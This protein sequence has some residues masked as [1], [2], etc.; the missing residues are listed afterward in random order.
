MNDHRSTVTEATDTIADTA[1]SAMFSYMLHSEEGVFR[2]DMFN[3]EA[4]LILAN[5]IATCCPFRHHTL[6]GLVGWCSTRTLLS[7]LFPLGPTLGKTD[8]QAGLPNFQLTKNKSRKKDG[9]GLP[10]EKDSLTAF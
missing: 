5:T 7:C 6:E 8:I 10:Q 1:Y 2:I 4:Q 9:Y 3:F